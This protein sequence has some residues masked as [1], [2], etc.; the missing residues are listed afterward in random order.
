ML[1]RDTKTK[2]DYLLEKGC[3]LDHKIKSSYFQDKTVVSERLGTIS[4]LKMYYST[5]PQNLK[6]AN[7]S[8]TCR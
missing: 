8:F 6:I 7:F 1:N 2:N 4:T 5:A 3:K